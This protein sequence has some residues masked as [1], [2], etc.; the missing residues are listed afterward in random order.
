MRR[1][2]FVSQILINVKF[3]FGSKRIASGQAR[4]G[5]VPSLLISP[6]RVRVPSA[7]FIQTK[8]RCPLPGS[9]LKSAVGAIEPTRE[10]LTMPA[11]HLVADV[12]VAP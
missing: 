6:V 2:I 11:P 9:A 5:E 3:I 12:P 7:N 1:Q 4:T 8:W 10:G